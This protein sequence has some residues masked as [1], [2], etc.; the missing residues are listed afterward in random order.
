M[1]KCMAD[2]IYRTQHSKQFF[3]CC[4]KDKA[5][6]ATKYNL[7]ACKWYTPKGGAFNAA[8]YQQ[9]LAEYRAERTGGS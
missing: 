9:F 4:I 5:F 6:P 8:E 1:K 7:R 2:C 3:Y